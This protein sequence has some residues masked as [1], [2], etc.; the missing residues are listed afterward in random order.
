MACLPSLSFTFYSESV[1]LTAFKTA[2][3]TKEE[4]TENILTTLLGSVRQGWWLLRH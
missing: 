1:A 2:E 4:E 3:P